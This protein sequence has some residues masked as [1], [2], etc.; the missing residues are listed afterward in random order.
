MQKADY[1]NEN[2]RYID[3]DSLAAIEACPDWAWLAVVEAC[4]EL[5]DSDDPGL[6]CTVAVTSETFADFEASRADWSEKGK[7]TLGE[8]EGIYVVYYRDFQIAKGDRRVSMAVV[9]AGDS[10]VCLTA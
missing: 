10:R 3:D 2:E 7:R 4:K 5:T 9:N 6:S 1:I 8:F